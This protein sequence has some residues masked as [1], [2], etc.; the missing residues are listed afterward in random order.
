MMT[1]E[2]KPG[3]V[4]CRKSVSA[5]ESLKE[6]EA[7]LACILKSNLRQRA[8]IY[9]KLEKT[10]GVSPQ[11]FRRRVAFMTW[12]EERHFYHFKP[13]SL[14]YVVVAAQRPDTVTI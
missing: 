1:A 5:I 4:W 9:Q 8:W 12:Y 14:C 11:T 7:E 10:A 6:F 2:D 13:M 3:K